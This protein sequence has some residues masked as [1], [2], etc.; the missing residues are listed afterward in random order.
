MN[1]HGL[2]LSMLAILPLTGL[3][4]CLEKKPVVA[5]FGLKECSRSEAKLADEILFEDASLKIL[6]KNLSKVCDGFRIYELRSSKEKSF[7]N[8][9]VLVRS[10][11]CTLEVATITSQDRSN[12]KPTSVTSRSVHLAALAFASNLGSE[13]KD[14]V[15]WK[16]ISDAEGEKLKKCFWD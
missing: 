11:D 6:P 9:F 1:Y 13:I 10:T 2:C 14:D 15:S 5:T 8:S 16:P 12:I 3:I 7:S 4:G